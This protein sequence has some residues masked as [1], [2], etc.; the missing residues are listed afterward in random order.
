MKQ[1]MLPAALCSLL[2]GAVVALASYLD[3]PDVAH[4]QSVTRDYPENGT[5][6]VVV[7]SASDDDGTVLAWSLTGIDGGDLSID[8]GALTFRRS[9][10]YENPADA[11]MDNVYEFSVTVTDGINTTSASM[12]VSVTN[13]DEPG[14]VFLSS[15][16]PE[17]GIPLTA[18]LND[19]DGRVSDVSWLWETSQDGAAWGP[20]GDAVADSY[21]PVAGDVG[22]YLRATASYA[23]GEGVGKSAL[24]MSHHVV[25]EVHPAGHAPEF[26]DSE[27]GMRSV[28][29][30]TG[31][32][33]NVGDPVAAE[34]EEGH[35][36]TYTLG[37]EDAAAFDIDR[38]TGQLL[39]RALLDHETRDSYTMTI[40]VSDPANAHDTIT[41]RVTITNLEEEGVL[42]LSTPQPHVD[43]EMSAY[44]DDPDGEVADVTWTWESPGDQAEWSAIDGADT[45]SYT[46]V[47]DDEGRHLRVTAAYTDGEGAGKSAQAVSLNPV[48]ELEVNH[49]PTFPATETGLRMV[50]EN[51]PP[52]AAIGEPFTAIDDHDHDHV[53]T[54]SL[55]GTDA[56]SFDIGV[57]TGQLLT[58]SPLDHE[59][60]RT[61]R[62]IVTVHDGEDP[63]GDPDHSSDATLAAVIVVTDVDEGAPP[64]V[65]V[66]GG[67]VP[68]SEDS[69]GLVHDCETLLQSRDALSGS[70]SLDWSTDTPI[71][72]WQGV[73][74]GGSPGRV[75]GISLRDGGLDGTIPTALGVISNLETLDLRDNGLTGEIPPQ[76]GNLT[77]LRELHLSGNSLSGCVP[78]HLRAVATNDLS[79]LDIRHCD[80][81]LAGLNIVPGEM[82][83]QFDPYVRRYT[84]V[85]D[86]SRITVIPTASD[87][88]TLEVLDNL[89]RP[90]ADA[91]D[92]GLGHQVDL[93]PGVTFARV[94]VV[95]TDGLASQLYTTLV[96]EGDLFRRYDANEDRGIDK[97]EVLRA[98][99]DYFDGDAT[100][101]EVI[102]IVQLYFFLD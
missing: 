29:E 22:G 64:S 57:N 78:G 84:A 50:P 67:A 101:D 8:A 11:D 93:S 36:L 32:G 4:A 35:V 3:A 90:L 76:L 49:S 81:L 13:V 102:G 24:V 7:F 58:K 83:Q 59:T 69:A 85:S 41:V 68:D 10:D 28:A 94:R 30:N 16:Q 6:T 65:C 95:S 91:D 5:S 98:V 20:I 21:T 56:G 72:D 52:G 46:P 92:S 44:L 48:H 62:V 55:E 89:S 18:S 27:T 88:V 43:E 86:A 37:G 12:T 63:H 61:Y 77:G 66:D 60:K 17:V 45:A 31:A 71:A 19:P 82:H 25:R 53:L 9:P 54:Y 39:T 96:C 38:S 14:I 34:D 2:L 33:I 47:E 99:R 73:T 70:G 74:V 87:G 15:L 51:T 80:V 79:D 97:D 42:T 23:D 75:T 1:I 26:P 100:R 40:M